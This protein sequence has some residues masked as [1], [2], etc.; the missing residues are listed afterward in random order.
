MTE[1][2]RRFLWSLPLIWISAAGLFLVLGNTEPIQGRLHLPLFFNPRPISAELAAREALSQLLSSDL[3]IRQSAQRAL[4]ELGGAALPTILP[5]VPSQSVRERRLV[6]ETLWPVAERMG[7]SGRPMWG[8]PFVRR[9]Q[10]EL[11]T[12]EK[13]LFWERYHEEHA[14]DL[15]PQSVRRVVR[16][17]AERDAELRQADL[18]AVDTYALPALVEHLGRVRDAEDVRRVARL[19]EKIRHVTGQDFY[20]S[21]DDSVDRARAVASEV[22]WFFDELGA[23]WTSMSR[24]ELLVARLSQTEFA[25]WLVRLTRQAIGLDHSETFVKIARASRKSL[26]LWAA[27]L[28]GLLLVGPAFV[29]SLQVLQLKQTRLRIERLGLRVCLAAGLLLLLPLLIRRRDA[30][31]A[32]LLLIALAAGMLFSTFVLQRELSD[33]LDWRSHHVLKGRSL[34]ARVLA[35]GGWIAPAIPT[36]TPIAVGEAALWVSALEMAT[37][38]Q[39]LGYFSIQAMRDGDLYFLMLVCLGLGALTGVSQMLADFVLGTARTQRGET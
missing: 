31:F 8:S 32:E 2:L 26:P 13:L 12:D 25:V 33:R 19:V 11:G 21:P 36:M 39:G 4:V 9:Q 28:A 3:S 14:L 37:A 6:A 35:V 17:V 22:R 29:A 7:L 38:T 24:V 23:Q 18:Y 34:R 5:D 16:R 10:Q 27:A 15:R 1:L 30:A 20:V